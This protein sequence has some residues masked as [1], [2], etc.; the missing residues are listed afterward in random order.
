MDAVPLKTSGGF[1]HIF[2]DE[3][4]RHHEYDYEEFE[5]AEDFFVGTKILKEKRRFL[6]IVDVVDETHEMYPVSPWKHTQKLG[7]AETVKMLETAAPLI[8]QAS[9]SFRSYEGSRT[10]MCS[11]V[12]KSPTTSWR[13]R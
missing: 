4:Y 9:C 1:A 3:K 7:E 12:V 13:T 8:D 6:R 11:T 5:N 2:L 10:L